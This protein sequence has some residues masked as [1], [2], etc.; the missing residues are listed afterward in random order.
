MNGAE[1]RQ[2]RSV[3]L[4]FA[5]CMA[6]CFLLST[7]GLADLMGDLA[8]PHEG[9]SMRATSTPGVGPDEKNV[10]SRRLVAPFHASRIP[11]HA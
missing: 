10:A 6:I 5:A 8:R 2:N 7:A 9:R 3:P 4:L 1:R 11:R